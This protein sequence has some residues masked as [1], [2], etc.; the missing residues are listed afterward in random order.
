MPR[1][2]SLLLACCAASDPRIPVAAPPYYHTRARA[3]TFASHLA[4]QYVIVE[5]LRAYLLSN[6]IGPRHAKGEPL[7]LGRRLD[8]GQIFNTGGSGYLLNI[9]A[10]KK[11]A[12]ALATEEGRSELKALYETLDLDGDGK[13]TSEEWSNGLGENERLL[14]KY[15]GGCTV[16]ENREVFRRIDADSNGSLSWDGARLCPRSLPSLHL[17]AMRYAPCNIICAMRLCARCAKYVTNYAPTCSFLH[18]YNTASLMCEISG[19]HVTVIIGKQ[20]KSSSSLSPP[21]VTN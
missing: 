5:N 1:R 17:W 9:H 7:Y 4:P 2:L 16:E 14:T 10:L 19:R 21:A 20:R 12:A 18:T 13:L 6:D 3:H 11:L 15:F 8:N